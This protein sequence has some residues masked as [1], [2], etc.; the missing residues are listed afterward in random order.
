MS[1]TAYEKANKIIRGNIRRHENSVQ[2]FSINLW[3]STKET[4]KT[5][6]YAYKLNI[7]D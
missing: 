4:D 7:D 5:L 2:F 1:D 3:L 6:Y